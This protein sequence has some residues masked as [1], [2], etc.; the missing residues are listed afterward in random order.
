[1]QNGSVTAIVAGAANLSKTTTGTV[2]L[3]GANSFS[4]TTTIS[5]GA[6]QANDGTG[7]PTGS[8]L[9]LDGGVLQ[10]DGVASF[11]RSL[12]TSGSSNFQWTANGGGF[13]ANGGKLTVTIANNAATEVVWGTTVGS[14]IVGTL[15]FGSAT[16]NAETEFQN[17]IDLGNGTRTVDVTAGTGGDF[18]TISGV[19][20]NS[21]GTGNLT[22]TG[23]GMLVLSGAN[24]YNG[25]TAVQVRV[26]FS[27]FS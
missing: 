14:Q 22:K 13:S 21:T 1:M 11:T 3:S 8:F 4:G 24:T 17:K 2:T 15:D 27:V 5:A 20:R 25:A 12:G 16:A 18:A 9:S 19:I 7:L 26:L 6:L 23:T 10:G